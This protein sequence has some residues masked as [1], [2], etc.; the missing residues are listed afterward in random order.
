MCPYVK[1][2]EFYADDLGEGAG[3]S[4]RRVEFVVPADMGAPVKEPEPEPPQPEYPRK[5]PMGGFQ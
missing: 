3:R 2:L 1:A 4:V 5:R